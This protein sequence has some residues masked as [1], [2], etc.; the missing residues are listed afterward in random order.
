MTSTQIVALALVL[1]AISDV[2]IWFLLLKPIHKRNTAQ[3]AVLP[4]EEKAAMLKKQRSLSLI[5]LGMA[6]W[7]VIALAIAYYL[8]NNPDTF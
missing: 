6:F 8:W 4:P 5:G 3:I 1:V 7:C 2:M